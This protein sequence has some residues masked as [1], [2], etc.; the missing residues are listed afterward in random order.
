MT[1]N[2]YRVFMISIC[3]PFGDVDAVFLPFTR[4][5]D[6]QI[7]NIGSSTCDGNGWFS[8]WEGWLAQRCIWLQFW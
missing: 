5:I 7:H 3:G 2:R 6:K 8:G 4:A 1:G